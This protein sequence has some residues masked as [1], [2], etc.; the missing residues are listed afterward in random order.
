MLKKPIT[1]SLILMF[2]ASCATPKAMDVRQAND[3]VMS[4][5]EL[6]LAFEQA[7]LSEDEAHA[8]IGTTDWYILSGLFFFPAYFVTYGTSVHAHFNA[9]QRKDHLLALYDKKGCA[10]PKSE[11]YRQLVSKT[12]HELEDLKDKY[13]RGIISEDDYILARKQ[14][15]IAFEW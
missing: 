15:L 9:S 11:E 8:E 1:Y 14:L 7:D 4:C 5:D 10:K 2:I 6:M 12:L 13:I 3:Y